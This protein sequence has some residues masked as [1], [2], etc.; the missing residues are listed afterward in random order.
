MRT[1]TLKKLVEEA[2]SQGAS[3][4][5][6]W[7]AAESK[8]PERHISWNYIVAIRRKYLDRIG[9]EPVSTDLTPEIGP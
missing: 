3:A 4:M 2:A 9:R 7:R 6:C 8:W 5:E 1:N